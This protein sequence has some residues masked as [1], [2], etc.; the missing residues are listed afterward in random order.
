MKTEFVSEVDLWS[1]YRSH[2]FIARCVWQL[3]FNEY[4]KEM[5]KLTDEEK[6]CPHYGLNHMDNMLC[7]YMALCSYFEKD[8]SSVQ[9]CWKFYSPSGM[10]NITNERPVISFDWDYHGYMLIDNQKGVFKFV[11]EKIIHKD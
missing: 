6:Q 11:L 4:R 8:W 2:T 5:D 1:A 10:T 9:I 7:D 3:L